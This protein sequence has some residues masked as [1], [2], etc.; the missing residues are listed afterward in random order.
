MVV[1]RY[2]TALAWMSLLRLT[3]GASLPSN[4]LQ[5]NS[6]SAEIPHIATNSLSDYAKFFWKNVTSRLRAS[7]A[8][9]DE[10]AFETT[11][12]K[13]ASPKTIQYGFQPSFE[14]HLHRPAINKKGGSSVPFKAWMD[15]QTPITQSNNKREETCDE[16]VFTCVGLKLSKVLGVAFG[17]GLLIALILPPILYFALSFIGIASHGKLQLTILSR[18]TVDSI[19]FFRTLGLALGFGVA[20]CRFSRGDEIGRKVFASFKGIA[21]SCLRN[22]FSFFPV[23]LIWISSGCVLG[24]IMWSRF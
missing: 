18:L 10:G 22:M 7:W 15:N 20:T 5:Q 16:L 14:K 9:P 13:R 23:L 17:G 6:S 2:L 11:A 19:T 3:L 24:W 4:V 12:E 8:N 1:F 21:E